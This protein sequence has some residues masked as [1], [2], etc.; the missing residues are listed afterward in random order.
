[1]HEQLEVTLS[2]HASAEGK[3]ARKKE[4][5]GVDKK[6]LE[7][8]QLINQIDAVRTTQTHARGLTRSCRAESHATPLLCCATQAKRRKL[9]MQ[10]AAAEAARAK[11]KEPVA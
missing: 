1:M 7:L 11:A 2:R 9:C 3:A 8:E 5:A 6:S 4:R 10:I